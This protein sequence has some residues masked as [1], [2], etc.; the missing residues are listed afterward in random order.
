[1][2]PRNRLRLCIL[3]NDVQA[4]LDAFGADVHIG[5]SDNFVDLSLRF[6]AERAGETRWVGVL[7]H[8]SQVFATISE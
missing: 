1:M 4:Q 5:A 3:T 7:R 2:P 6:V 8:V